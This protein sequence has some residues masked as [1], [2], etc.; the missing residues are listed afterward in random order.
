V[1]G[2]DDD[3]VLVVVKDGGCG[4]RLSQWV[5]GGRYGGGPQDKGKTECV[6][7]DVG[8]ERVKTTDYSICLYRR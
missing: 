3:M 5:D 1:D 2:F 7:D 4:W 8:L 6:G